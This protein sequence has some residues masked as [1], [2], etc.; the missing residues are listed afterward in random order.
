ME[1]QYKKRSIEFFDKWGG[2]TKFLYFTGNINFKN[3]WKTIEQENND[4]ML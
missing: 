1:R 3:T 2:H 4:R